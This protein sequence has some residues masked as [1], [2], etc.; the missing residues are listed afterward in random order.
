ML[1]VQGPPG[2]AAPV[3]HLVLL[4]GL[5]GVGKRFAPF[6]S[7]LGSA[8]TVELV[9]YPVD[10]PLGYAQLEARV[11]A[12]LPRAARFVLLGESFSGPLA[13]RIGADPPPGLAGVILCSSFA[14]FPL[15]VP[16]WAVPLAAHAPLKALPRWLRAL[17]QWGSLDPRRAPRAEE[18][19]M[20][21]VSSEVIRHRLAE[22]LRIDVRASLGAVRMP[23]LVVSGRGD[24]LLS[25]RTARVLARAA[26]H[27]RLVEI[28][29]PHALLQSRPEACAEAV[30]QFLRRWI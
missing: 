9:R 5:D 24:W 30:L 11:R 7:A 13:I 10:E 18:R 2:G 8:A 12:A 23:L 29:G 25:R 6:M 22:L 4:P 20:A 1:S 16:R 26:P 3:P 28:E 19:S 21:G 17:V 14:R 15:R 27:G